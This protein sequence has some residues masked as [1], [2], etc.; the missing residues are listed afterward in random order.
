MS[1]IAD[2]ISLQEDSSEN[3]KVLYSSLSSLDRIIGGF[4]SSKIT[5]LDSGSDFI[6]DLSFLLCVR[7]I[8]ENG[9]EIIFVD[10]GNSIDPYA[11]ACI[12]KRY[13]LSRLEVLPMINVARAFTAYQM[14]TLLLEMLEAQVRK[15]G[16]NLVLLSCL[17]NL[18]LDEDVEQREAHQLLMRSL[19]KIKEITEREELIT[20]ITNYGLT[21]LYRRRG[22]RNLLYEGAHKVVR[23]HNSQGKLIVSLPE[24]GIQEYYQPVPPSQI[25]LD[26]FF[27]GG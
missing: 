16:A 17:P 19:R 25:T 23:F 20:I 26:D 18:F 9:R 3:G 14:S 21:K 1:A 11:I 2:V 15:C 22:L 4:E 12:S 7:N 24:K 27:K 10:G 6:F 5:F 8:I 13:G